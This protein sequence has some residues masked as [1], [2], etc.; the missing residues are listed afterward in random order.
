MPSLDF[1]KIFIANRHLKTLDQLLEIGIPEEKIFLTSLDLF[2]EYHSKNPEGRVKF[3]AN[4]VLTSKLHLTKLLDSQIAQ[5]D[6]NFFFDVKDGT[7]IGILQLLAKEIEEQKIAGEIAELGVFQGDFSKYLNRLFPNRTLN[8]FDT[9]EGFDSKDIS[10]DIKN[11]LATKRDIDTAERLRDTSVDL[12]L[13][14][15]KNPERVKVYKGYFPD[16]IPAESKTFALVS[17]DVDLYAPALEGL[18]YFYPRL[19]S[20]GYIMLHDYNDISYAKSIHKAVEE[21]EMEFGRISKL[22]IPDEHGSLVIAK[23]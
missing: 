17:I 14:K 23:C 1:D 8:L 12:V 9:F 16:T 4:A 21:F 7:R 15:M 10:V 13:S 3:A 18:K 6:G 20:G 2:H 5:L 11:D 19:A 22:P